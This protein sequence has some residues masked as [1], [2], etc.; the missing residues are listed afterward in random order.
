MSLNSLSFLQRALLRPSPRNRAPAG[1]SRRFSVSV[2]IAAAA[3]LTTV[4]ACRPSQ[5]PGGGMH[6]MPPAQVVVAPAQAGS[7]PVVFEYI[8]QTVG[9]KEVEVRSRVGGILE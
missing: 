2:A 9:S 4:A 3:L 8:G 5:P 1:P 6:G 7:I